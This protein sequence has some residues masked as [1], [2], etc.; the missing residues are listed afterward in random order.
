VPFSGDVFCFALCGNI[1]LMKIVKEQKNAVGETYVIITLD[2]EKGI[3]QDT[4]IGPFG[5]QDNFRNGVSQ[6]LDVLVNSKGKIYGWL[7][8]LRD[9]KGSWDSSRQWMAE[10][11]MPKAIKSGLK[12]EAVVLPRNIFSKLSTKDTIM[13]MTGFELRQFE[14]IEEARLWLLSMN[15]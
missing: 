14:D 7:A 5:T 4:W 2:E 8:D 12:A 1:T 6:V 11:V 3:I 9:M 10:S 13:K 15:N